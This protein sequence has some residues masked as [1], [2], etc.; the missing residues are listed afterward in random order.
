MMIDAGRNSWIMLCILSAY[1]ELS[2]DKDDTADIDI[3]MER[4]LKVF[5]SGTR[6]HSFKNVAS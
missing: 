2:G 6:L 4:K 3:Q 5:E 1:G